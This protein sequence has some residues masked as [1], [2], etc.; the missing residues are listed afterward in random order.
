M[1]KF[2]V[3][4][5][6]KKSR[7]ESASRLRCVVWGVA[8]PAACSTS[9]R[10]SPAPPNSTGNGQAGGAAAKPPPANPTTPEDSKIT[11]RCC[12]TSRVSR[13]MFDISSSA[14][15]LSGLFTSISDIGQPCRESLSR[16][17]LAKNIRV[18]RSRSQL[19]EVMHRAPTGTGGGAASLDYARLNRWVREGRVIM[20]ASEEHF[21]RPNRQERFADG[22]TREAARDDLR[23]GLAAL[24]SGVEPHS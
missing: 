17:S 3:F 8:R 2:E 6:A 12:S 4:P 22:L 9:T 24:L 10:A 16:L 13:R 18:Y 21:R 1:R 7:R 23:T 15:A 11:R 14:S 19:D 20:A 5:T